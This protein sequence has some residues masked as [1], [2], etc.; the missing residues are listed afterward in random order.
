MIAMVVCLT[1]VLMVLLSLVLVG[2][3]L[4]REAPSWWLGAIRKSAS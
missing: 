2:V 4:F 3:A 1:L